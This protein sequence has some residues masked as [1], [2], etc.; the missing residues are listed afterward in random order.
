MNSQSPPAEEPRSQEFNRKATPWPPFDLQVFAR[1]SERKYRAAEAV[2]K[3]PTAPPPPFHPASAGSIIVAKA[4]TPSHIEGSAIEE[5]LSEC[6][7]RLQ[8]LLV[9][10]RSGGLSREET[11]NVLRLELCSI[12]TEARA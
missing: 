9:Q 11:A 6:A 8:P 10:L 2:E 4:A 12:E 1:D 5:R 3:S 7:T